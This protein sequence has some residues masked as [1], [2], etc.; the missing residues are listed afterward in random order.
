MEQQE[1]VPEFGIQTR[2][3]VEKNRRDEIRSRCHFIEK[4]PKRDKG[5]GR[6]PIRRPSQ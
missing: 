5:G 2:G 3:L 4:S 6:R 1:R